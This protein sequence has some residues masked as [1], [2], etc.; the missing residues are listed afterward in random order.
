MSTSINKRIEDAEK[1]LQ[2]FKRTESF[3]GYVAITKQNV[4]LPDAVNDDLG[5]PS[6]VLQIKI[7]S[8]SAQDDDLMISIGGVKIFDTRLRANAYYGEKVQYNPLWQT[9]GFRIATV[10]RNEAIN[11]GAT[12]EVG[13]NVLI[14]TANV[15]GPNWRTG[16]WIAYLSL[17][18]G[19]TI[20][21]SGGTTEIGSG[22]G[23][24][25]VINN[26]PIYYSNG[27]FK[28]I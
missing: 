13:S 23:T 10:T 5:T 27:N 28:L 6:R 14:N 7:V 20:S 17:D 22:A 21:I 15:N 12:W 11:K 16:R 18:S 24:P 19:V 2:E 1:R 8:L 4:V 9:E 26:P 25:G 3:K